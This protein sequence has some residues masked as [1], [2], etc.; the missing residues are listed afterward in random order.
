LIHHRAAYEAYTL[1][2]RPMGFEV[3]SSA[4]SLYNGAFEVS[5]DG[6]ISFSAHRT[7]VF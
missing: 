7:A 4:P 1:V 2:Y 6:S 3:H 5:N